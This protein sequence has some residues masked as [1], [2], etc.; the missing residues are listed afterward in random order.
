MMTYNDVK[1]RM[2]WNYQ[3]GFETQ[4]IHS[5]TKAERLCAIVLNWPDDGGIVIKTLRKGSEL[6]PGD[7]KLVVMLGCS[8]QIKYRRT[9]AG[10]ETTLPKERPRNYA[11][12]FSID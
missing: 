11:Y 5:T 12:T 3:Q 10:L 2:N 9:T 6:Y 7:I 8:K 4:D 1:K